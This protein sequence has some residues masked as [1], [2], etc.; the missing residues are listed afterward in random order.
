MIFCAKFYFSAQMATMAIGNANP[1]W[2]GIANGQISSIFS[3]YIC[4]GHSHIPVIRAFVISRGLLKGHLV[5]VQGN[6]SFYCSI[7]RY[8]I[9]TH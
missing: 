3:R 1:V 5:I 7:K 6:F 4:L 2:F 8:I 9:G